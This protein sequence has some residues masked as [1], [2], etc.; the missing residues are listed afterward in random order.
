[1]GPFPIPQQEGQTRFVLEITETGDRLCG[2]WKFDGS[3]C[4]AIDPM[5]FPQFWEAILARALDEPDVSI[6]D[7]RL[8]CRDF[9]LREEWHF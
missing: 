3:G 6:G 7:L 9:E 4:P 5:R 8:E 2:Y 1:M